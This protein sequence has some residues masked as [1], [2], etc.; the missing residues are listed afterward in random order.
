MSTKTYFPLNFLTIGKKNGGTT[1]AGIYLRWVVKPYLGL[2]GISPLH[3]SELREK[4]SEKCG[5]RLFYN[6]EDRDIP[7]PIPLSLD[8]II[9]SEPLFSVATLWKQ[10]GWKAFYNSE[11]KETEVNLNLEKNYKHKIRYLRFN[12]ALYRN[13]LLK[14][15]YTI[16]NDNTK[17]KTDYEVSLHYSSLLNTIKESKPEN[18]TYAIHVN[19]P[20]ESITELYFT[21]N[22]SVVLGDFYYADS[23]H[24]SFFIWSPEGGG[25]EWNEIE[26][27]KY[28]M[29]TNNAQLIKPASTSLLVRAMMEFYNK[30]FHI[31]P[32]GP[33]RAGKISFFYPDLSQFQLTQPL[34]REYITDQ[35]DQ[36][37]IGN[38]GTDPPSHNEFYIPP[39][40]AA[41]LVSNDPAIAHLLGLFRILKM[42]PETDRRCVYKLQGTWPDG[43]RFCIYSPYKPSLEL[44]PPRIRAAKAQQKKSDRVLRDFATFRVHHP[45]NVA[46]LFWVEEKTSSTGPNIRWLSPAAYLTLRS[47][48]PKPEVECLS[49]FFIPQE[50]DYQKSS[51]EI[52]Y[53]NWY[54][55]YPTTDI[56]KVL[57]GN[58]KYYLA[59]FD[60][61]G[62]MSD[63]DTMQTRIDPLKLEFGEIQKP[64]ITLSKLPNLSQPD[65]LETVESP[66]EVIKKGPSYWLKEYGTD[67]LTFD[68]SFFWPLASRYIWNENRATNSPSLHYFK[69]LY[70]ADTPLFSHAKF[71]IDNN[72][73]SGLDVKLEEVRE[74]T[75]SQQWKNSAV[76]ALVKKLGATS[77]SGSL[78]KAKTEAALKGGRVFFG[79]EFK[80]INVN[81]FA[82][83]ETITL[84]LLPTQK[85]KQ[86]KEDENGFY[87]PYPPDSQELYSD[88][89]GGQLYWNIDAKYSGAQIGWE[90]LSYVGEKIKP[91][92][93]EDYVDLFIKNI[94]LKY[95]FSINVDEKF[96]N[97]LKQQKI[98]A[99]LKKVFKDNGNPL[100]INATITVISEKKWEIIDGKQKFVI[101]ESNNQLSIYTPTSSCKM[102]K[103]LVPGAGLICYSPP[104]GDDDDYYFTIQLPKSDPLFKN[105]CSFQVIALDPDSNLE[106]GE[107]KRDSLPPDGEIDVPVS[108]KILFSEER[109]FSFYVV[110]I[111]DDPQQPDQAIFRGEPMSFT[112]T[113]D[114]SA[115][116]YLVYPDPNHKKWRIIVPNRVEGKKL[117][118]KCFLEGKMFNED[119]YL[120]S[121]LSLA[122]EAVVTGQ[123][124][125]V[126]NSLQ[127]VIATKKMS[128]VE[129]L[130][131]PSLKIDE[132]PQPRFGI[133]ANPPDYNGRSLIC[134]KT[135][136]E[137]Y[138]LE[139][140]LPKHLEYLLYRLPADRLVDGGMSLEYAQDP[141]SGNIYRRNMQI[142]VKKQVWKLFKDFAQKVEEKA[143]P[144]DKLLNLPV[145]LPGESRTVFLYAIKAYDKK[146]KKESEEFRSLSPP[147][148]VE[149]TTKPGVPLIK[150]ADIALKSD[151]I[152]ITINVARK[153]NATDGY[154]YVSESYLANNPSMRKANFPHFVKQY[155]LYLSNDNE[156]VAN[157]DDS[158]FALITDMSTPIGDVDN[159]PGFDPTKFSIR[160][161]PGILQITEPTDIYDYIEVGVKLQFANSVALS[162]I[163][164]RIYLCLRAENYL[165]QVSSLRFSPYSL[166]DV[167]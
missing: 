87:L 115:K 98:S 148:Y 55:R 77:A 72:T 68:F 38:M 69:L 113:A 105:R 10:N 125:E 156:V 141:N 154:G 138:K 17:R 146:A 94:A 56:N 42:I 13:Q 66:L 65:A 32:D 47:S 108:A 129:Y 11:K 74:S 142:K 33:V 45:I 29:K 50:Q 71:K 128:F 110:P 80:I 23:P 57:D 52:H 165:G 120:S 19:H 67:N 130:P 34:K 14:L 84:R 48:P 122:V 83:S 60:I 139:A 2:F 3:P 155:R 24:V 133:A 51:K 46:D 88:E 92:P 134:V 150:L 161:L 64:E 27:D 61:F 54:D 126:K 73:Y 43:K 89:H 95:L 104:E 15:R 158:D 136:Y 85:T 167:V 163:P 28:L 41:A 118:L 6:K 21:S 44:V 63:F 16:Y 106:P 5:F 100:P 114:G 81:V 90:T 140:K 143:L 107:Y 79:R 62:Q 58:Y 137:G 132:L 49:S 20:S 26:S 4:E 9:P 91:T 147:V 76:F 1:A 124:P 162:D 157:P 30:Y 111:A 127:R 152:E 35:Y 82:S 40:D 53:L 145:V 96:K 164:A 159:L 151:T 160:L 37:C 75:G 131:P 7:S 8:S 36:L 39:Q 12:Y 25:G 31:Q 135:I 119:N 166:R 59:C 149:D 117:P 99:D 22:S 116:E 93:P 123:D 153:R 144:K 101:R 97:D 109:I 103:D 18:L 121:S 70:L 102:P 78:L 112:S 86:E